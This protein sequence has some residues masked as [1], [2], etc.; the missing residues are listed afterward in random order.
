MIISFGEV[1]IDFLPRSLN[2]DGGTTSGYLPIVG[3]SPANVAVGIS[4]LGVKS[5]FAGGISTDFFGDQIRAHLQQSDVDFSFSPAMQNSSTLAFVALD[6]EEPQYAFFD[7]NSANRNYVVP[8]TEE[9]AR[10]ATALHFGS[11]SIGVEPLGTKLE[12]IM[13]SCSDT[14]LISLDPNIRADLIPDEQAYRARLKRCYAHAHIIKISIADL[15]WLEPKKPY[16][17]VAQEWLQGGAQLVV[18]THGSKGSHAFTNKDDVKFGATKTEIVDTVGAGDSFMSGLLAY[19]HGENVLTPKTIENLD[20][21]TIEKAL[22]FASKCAAITVSRAG[23][24]PPYLAE[25]QAE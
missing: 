25:L 2:E 19:L 18:I 21:G 14:H 13:A 1:L 8:S 5:G 4:R 7:E 3:G 20:I 22:G 11:F 9:L 24:N 10:A 12:T 17:L 15:E 16:Q 23:A 6:S